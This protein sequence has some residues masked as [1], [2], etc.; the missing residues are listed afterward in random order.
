[1]VWTKINYTCV[2]LLRV[3]RVPASTVQRTASLQNVRFIMWLTVSFDV[4][5][6]LWLRICFDVR[7]LL[8]LMTYFNVRSLLW[9][10]VCVVYHFWRAWHAFGVHLSRFC[11]W[12]RVSACYFCCDSMIICFD[13]QFMLWLT[14]FYVRFVV[15]NV[16]WCTI[17]FVIN[18]HWCTI[19]VVTNTNVGHVFD[20]RCRRRMEAHPYFAPRRQLARTC[21]L[22][23]Q[24]RWRRA[25]VPSTTSGSSMVSH[26]TAP[27]EPRTF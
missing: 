14:S 21:L 13:G 8:Y 19:S 1:M 20:T 12:R 4:Q 7:F 11:N 6:M 26:R 22:G 24:P 5:F 25:M 10:T 16:F 18:V 17:S 15:A 9:L 23:S 3:D 2:A 27:T